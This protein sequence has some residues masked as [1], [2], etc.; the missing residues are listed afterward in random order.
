VIGK[1][2][3]AIINRLPTNVHI[4][5]EVSSSKAPCKTCPIPVGGVAAHPTATPEPDNMRLSPHPALQKTGS[6]YEGFVPMDFIVT[7]TVQ[8]YR[9]AGVLSLELPSL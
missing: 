2:A 4:K 1:R 5:V 3:V 8:Q 9:L 7:V 6:L